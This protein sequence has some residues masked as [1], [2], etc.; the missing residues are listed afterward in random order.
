MRLA[1]RLAG[2]EA[3]PGRIFA[4]LACAVALLM[5]YRDAVALRL[6]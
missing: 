2:H 4:V 3:L 1:I 5:L 6:V